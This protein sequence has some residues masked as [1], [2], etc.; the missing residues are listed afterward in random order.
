MNTTRRTWIGSL[1]GG[2]AAC[3]FG[4]GVAAAR[5]V[6]GNPKL[7]AVGIDYD[8]TINPIADLGYAPDEEMRA[9][10]RLL[11]MPAGSLQR[12]RCRTVGLD[13]PQEMI[14]FQNNV[15]LSTEKLHRLNMIVVALFRDR[16]DKLAKMSSWV[17][18]YRESRHV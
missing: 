4:G 1:I 12:I 10:E 16:M 5:L 13:S 7:E 17:V 15:P 11:E 3:L 9:I 6:Q 2:V 14:G 18:T 8:G